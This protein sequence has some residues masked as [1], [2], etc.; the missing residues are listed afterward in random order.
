V[1]THNVL[2]IIQHHIFQYN[3]AKLAYGDGALKPPHTTNVD[4]FRPSPVPRNG[5]RGS[6]GWLGDP[7]V[8]ASTQQPFNPNTYN[9]AIHS[10]PQRPPVPPPNFT[11]D[12]G[13]SFGSAPPRSQQPRGRERKPCAFIEFLQMNI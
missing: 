7:T 2:C 1:F 3:Q 9:S 13:S 4:F 10:A 8:Q 12:I 5:I 11:P 6:S